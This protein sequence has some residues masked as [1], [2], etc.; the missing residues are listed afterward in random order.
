MLR[1]GRG[2]AGCVAPNGG[3][4]RACFTVIHQTV[5][6]VSWTLHLRLFL[7]TERVPKEGSVMG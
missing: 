4:P 1:G 3:D 2:E 7:M 5:I 6:F